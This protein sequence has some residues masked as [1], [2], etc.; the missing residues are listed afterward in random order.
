[1]ARPLFSE[2]DA[3]N[4]LGQSATDARRSVRELVTRLKARSAAELAA[5][6]DRAASALAAAKP[7]E[8]LEDDD[9]FMSW[10]QVESLE[11]SAGV[12]LGS[13]AH[14]HMPL[15]RLDAPALSNDLITAQRILGDNVRRPVTTFAY[16]NGD[17]DSRVVDAV[18]ALGYRLGFT[19]VGGWVEAGDD[20]LR[21][22]RL[23]IGERGTESR[24]QFLCRLLGW[25]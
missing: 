3:A 4:I 22:K 12:E 1:V 18:R 19:T 23:N 7:A 14:S 16:P 9:R 20:V 10:S 24:P 2:L 8:T 5:I 21:L 15:T 11:Q 6:S 17:H 25:L 13:H